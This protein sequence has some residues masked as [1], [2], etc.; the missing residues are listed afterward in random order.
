MIR[1]LLHL[2]VVLLAFVALP[3]KAQDRAVAAH[4]I[5]QLESETLVSLRFA[6]GAVIW[7]SVGGRAHGN[8]IVS[9]E[10][11]TGVVLLL[12]A[13]G[14]S[15]Q[16]NLPPGRIRSE[17]TASDPQHRHSKVLKFGAPAGA[18]E[19]APALPVFELYEEFP[20]R[21]TKRSNRGLD[22]DFIH[23]DRNKFRDRPD[24]E[25]GPYKVA[26]WL[27]LSPEKKS[28]MVE[29]LRQHGWHIQVSASSYG[30]T[31]QAKRALPSDPREIEF[32]LA[33]P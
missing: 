29:R 22:W 2:A 8:V 16:L 33:T 27:K 26:A 15:Y 12:D 11:Q 23:S 24:V 19:P 21:G 20:A 25:F 31:L 9:A 1:R 28:E 10:A 4:G 30:V 3:S 18:A 17:P 32:P 7:A 6:D 13:N 14:A 5:A